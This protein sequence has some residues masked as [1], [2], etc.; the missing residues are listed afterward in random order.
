MKRLMTYFFLLMLP[1]ILGAQLI[2]LNYEYLLNPVLINPACAGLDGSAIFSFS[3]RKQWDG[4]KDAPEF[5]SI[6]IDTRLRKMAKYDHSGVKNRNYIFPSSGKA[7]V[8]FNA[9]RD[10]NVPFNRTGVQIGYAYHSPLARGKAGT[11]SAGLGFQIYQQKLDLNYLQEFRN[12]D[13]ALYNYENR[14]I[15]N[16]AAGVVYQFKAFTF[17]SSGLFIVPTK[18]NQ[19]D[20][21]YTEWTKYQLFFAGS[22][23][24]KLGDDFRYTPQLVYKTT[25]GRMEVNQEFELF[26]S[27]LIHVL[28]NSE[29]Q[30]GFMAG[31]Q[32]GNYRVGY[33]FEYQYGE[34]KNYVEGS[35]MIYFSFVM[36]DINK[37]H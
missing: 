32:L 9:T 22:Y 12:T 2:P 36:P 24:F 35:H 11:L 33:A 5:Q 30:A 10:I 18:L 27:I 16:L 37:T 23:T 3:L 21:S 34:V 25:P 7:G 6:G 13:P 4:I 31:L 15:P 1:G 29:E 17:Q 19:A 28:W 26:K 8:Y 20:A 14:L